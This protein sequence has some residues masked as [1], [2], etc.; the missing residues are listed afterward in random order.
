MV[1]WAEWYSVRCIT[2]AHLI[3]YITGVNLRK[4]YPFFCSV[5][6]KIT[7]E[8]NTDQTSHPCA[9]GNAHQHSQSHS[10]IIRFRARILRWGEFLRLNYSKRK[11]L[12]WSTPSPWKRGEWRYRPFPKTMMN[13]INS[14]IQLQGYNHTT[15]YGN[16]LYP[17]IFVNRIINGR[18][19]EELAARH[20]SGSVAVCGV[21]HQ[22]TSMNPYAAQSEVCHIWGWLDAKCQ[23]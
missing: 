19:S 15:L 11:S 7:T 20:R 1:C 17:R 3:S 2:C 12:H 13:L 21:S 9:A 16:P 14:E 4:C 8:R 6:H 5:R 22:K 18:Q 23:Q 10:W